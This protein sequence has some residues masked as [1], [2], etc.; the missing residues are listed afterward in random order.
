MEYLTTIHNFL[1]DGRTIYV[2]TFGIILW[3]LMGCPCSKKDWI[4]V[5]NLLFNQTKGEA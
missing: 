2:A 4:D 3:S 5:Y 1:N